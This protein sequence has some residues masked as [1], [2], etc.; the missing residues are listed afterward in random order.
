MKCADDQSLPKCMKSVNRL[1]GDSFHRVLGRWRHGGGTSGRIGGY[2]GVDAEEDVLGSVRLP[3]AVVLRG[4]RRP[5]LLAVDAGA[6]AALPSL[7]NAIEELGL[8]LQDP[9][10]RSGIVASPASFL[11]LVELGP[12]AGGVPSCLRAGLEVGWLVRRGLLFVAFVLGYPVITK[13]RWE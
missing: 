9:T 13:A 6:G 2:R 7:A 3:H 4:Y 5:V 10:A 12:V 1:N 11:L 8:L